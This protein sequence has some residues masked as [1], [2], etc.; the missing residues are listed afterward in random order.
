[1]WVL[2]LPMRSI[3]LFAFALLVGCGVTD[4]DST[5]ASREDAA[6]ANSALIWSTA[7][8][9]VCWE[10]PADGDAEARG[11]VRDAVATTWETA[12]KLRFT[13]WE[14]CAADAR[15][16]RIAVID[17]GPKVE[18]FGTDLD[19]LASG[20]LLNFK[21][22]TFNPGCRQDYVRRACIA[23]DAAHEFGHAIG[24]LH[25]HDRPDHTACERQTM[26]AGGYPATALMIGAY[27]PDSIMNYCAKDY[28]TRGGLPYLSPGDVSAAQK[29]YG[30]P[31]R[32]KG[33]M[34]SAPTATLRIESAFDLDGFT[35]R[36]AEP[37][38][39]G[40]PDTS[41]GRSG[42]ETAIAADTKVAATVQCVFTQKG[43]L[44]TPAVCKHLEP[45]STTTITLGQLHVTRSRGERVFG[46]DTSPRGTTEYLA[47]AERMPHVPQHVKRGDIGAIEYDVTAGTV[48][49]LD[50]NDVTGY[51]SMR[52]VPVDASARHMPEAI[53]WRTIEMMA[54]TASAGL[55]YAMRDGKPFLVR[56]RA[57]F[58]VRL[59]SSAAQVPS[60]AV[61]A[62]PVELKMGRLEIAGP[63]NP[64]GG[65]WPAIYRFTD[66]TLGDRDFPA[67]SGMDVAPG[68]YHVQ[69]SWVEPPA[70][71]IH[72]EDRTIVVP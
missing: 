55:D 22:G 31:D 30:V 45:G 5:T 14:E 58:T 12:T 7:T 3:G 65:T 68:T 51:A 59:D 47:G 70:S 61:G 41:I 16:I 34:P 72:A 25:E 11:W 21:F 35:V 28:I 19:G 49:E 13:G 67:N 39:N 54:G 64:A 1:M 29:Y 26:P 8:I 37:D 2:S 23:W 33:T 17:A 52:V 53:T 66:G 36:I 9:P 60:G 32:W 15:G 50:L 38:V 62:A 69:V 56:H 48:T 46:V 10:S 42:R 24:F 71:D 20:M 57:P 27:D 43:G 44:R 40:L 4:D 18:K 63:A 6:Y